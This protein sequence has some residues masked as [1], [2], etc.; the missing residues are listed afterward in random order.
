MIQSMKHYWW[1]ILLRGVVALLF[2]V[3]T[4]L[5]PGLTAVTLVLAF[6]SYA[7]VSGVLTLVFA[8]FS[9]AASHHRAMH[10]LQGGLQTLLGVLVL[11]W[12]GITTL[13]LLVAIISFA[14]LSGIVE[15]VMA[16]QT[17][18]FWLG[19]SGLASVI[20]G[21]YAFRFPGE[22]ALTILLLIGAYAVVAGVM[23]IIGSFR[24]RQMNDT[25]LGH[26]A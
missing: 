4:L 7:L 24:V 12:P 1:L 18:N 19:L 11:T 17:R 14:F 10:G 25:L 13:S 6:G 5:N 16:F 26:M 21:V 2:G 23:L 8:L 15:V 20:F 22:G 9:Q 3:F